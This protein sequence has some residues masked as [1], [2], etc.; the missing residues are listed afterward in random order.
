[1]LIRQIASILVLPF[2][3]TVLMPLWIARRTALVLAAPDD[4]QSVGVVAAGVGLAL[5]GLALVCW[6]VYHF[7]THGRGTLAPWDPPRRFVVE[8]PYRYVRNPMIGGV[9]LVLLGEGLFLRSLGLLEWAAAFTLLNAVYIPLLEEPILR[10]RF[11]APY[12]R[13][14]ERVRRFVPRL[15]PYDTESAI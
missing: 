13:Y 10:A 3:V 4:L 2:A 9:V 14:S 12:V 5:A 8:G 15:T 1:M 7:W 6:S 11:G